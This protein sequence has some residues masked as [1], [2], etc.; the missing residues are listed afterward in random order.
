MGLFAVL[1]E[2][3]LSVQ[4]ILAQLAGLPAYQELWR[5]LKNYQGEQAAY[6]LDGTHKVAL[7]AGLLRDQNTPTIIIVRDEKQATRW[8]DTLQILLPKREIRYFPPVD[9]R[10]R[11]LLLADSHHLTKIRLDSLEILQTEPNGIIVTTIEA[12]LSSLPSPQLLRD[13]T[14]HIKTGQRLDF[15]D[16]RQN[17]LTAGYHRVTQVDGRAQFSIRGD[18]LDIY[19][20]QADPIRIEFFGDEVDSLR[21]FDIG[22]QRT[23][24][25]LDEVTI[26]PASEQCWLPED[27]NSGLRLLNNDI[28]R[29]LK[30]FPQH[31]SAERWAR[32]YESLRQHSGSYGLEQYAIYFQQAASLFDYAEQP[33]VIWD[34]PARLEDLAVRLLDELKN[35][36]DLLP[37][38]QANI[39]TYHH[40]VDQ[41]R[42]QGKLLTMALL[43]RQVSGHQPVAIHSFTARQAPSFFGQLELLEE[44][45]RQ[46]QEQKFRV[47]LSCNTAHQAQELA[48]FLQE[49]F[50]FVYSVD[51]LPL[52]LPSGHVYVIRGDLAQGFEAP[53]IHLI[54]LTA[55]EIFGTQQR[56][57]KRQ[58]QQS[59][60]RKRLT[61]YRELQV[62]D[63]VVH[64][65]HG[66]GVYQG[67][68]TMEYDGVHR[69]Y[70][71][72]RYKGE[73]RLYVPVEQ[74]QLVQKYIG[75]EGKKPRLYALGNNEWQRV[76][77]RVKASV[78]DMAE[79][80]LK[81]Y[82]KR[83]AVV[84]VKYPADD[85]WQDEFEHSFPFE[86]TEDQLKA[87]SDVK[88]DMMNSK[89]MDRL[90]CGDV[91][92]GKTEVALRAIF[93]AAMHGKQVAVLVP[94]TIL[95]HQHFRTFQSR[96]APY[97]LK[98]AMMS[99]FRSHKENQKTIEELAMGTVDIV[100]GTHAILG[101]KVQ[102]H[103]LG[104]LVI[105]EEQRFGVRHKETIKNLKN[106]IDVIT[107]TATPI[108]RTLHMS[109]VGMR[110]L[111]MIAT[112]PANR[113]P[114]QTY[115][116][117]Y[118][119]KMIKECVERELERGGQV[120]Y[121]HNRVRDIEYVA[122]KLRQMMPEARIA[123]AHGRMNE[124]HLEQLM[125]DFY[126]YEYD[127][128]VST[129]IIESG[130]DIPNVN[131][132]IIE[133]ADQFG[134]AQLYQIR[135]RVGR[136]NR[137]AYAYLTYKKHKVLSEVAEKRLNA[138][139]EFTELGAGFKIALRDLQ[140]RG[141]GNVL[142]PEQSG[143]M[144]QVGYDLYVQL[145]DETI[146][147]LKGEVIEVEQEM[148]MDLNI[149]AFIPNRYISD[150]KLKIEMYK[151]IIGCRHVGD[152][153]DVL[154]ELIDRFGEPPMPVRKLL[155]VAEVKA[156][157]QKLQVTALKRRGKSYGLTF[158]AKTVL[159]PEVIQ[160]WWKEFGTQLAWDRHNRST[161]WITTSGEDHEAQLRELSGI[162]HSLLD[163]V[164][165]N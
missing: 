66:I 164:L 114:V 16:L 9:V 104:L 128:L 96:L 7:T 134:L 160:S 85:Q 127:I 41:A 17:L 150:N 56:K 58:P 53:E 63:Y 133:D 110:D 146:R 158:D 3:V 159:N 29:M 27:M 33:L 71:A 122:G 105:D 10:L 47:V 113:Y 30:N 37:H 68:K 109:M 65:S 162:I 55:I 40:L 82:A 21:Y 142:G 36:Q 38:Q 99:R 15:S 161:I 124:R 112:P 74:I 129:T 108:P 60:D 79:E 8:Q 139:R 98:I 24:R 137:L 28:K 86:E 49:R 95:A 156:A 73:D 92:Y 45:L 163:R 152:I 43:T 52:E 83:E 131:T 153:R 140:I 149:D 75:S 93:K 26:R 84:G 31:H 144:M 147:E 6:G 2:E 141:A 32:D 165:D 61:D 67:I 78:Q 132:L 72:I 138:I 126:N 18:I 20:L 151:R 50:S 4:H 107:L 46:W 145:L 59:D 121:L 62:G 116:L 44:Q 91:G 81:L 34:D 94:T 69:D 157:C 117:E 101:S 154:D 120:Y 118:D 5:Q 22:D 125:L 80:L 11:H 143:F 155:L 103:D 88:Q 97:P 87:I 51:E 89:P 115:I 39:F 64:I 25:V 148:E 14:W 76:K 54:V 123:V 70:L 57:V 77:A 130:L 1:N 35:N 23:I 119:L 106:N 111:S 102:F 48:T 13:L 136:T 100:V 90:L 12:I 42:H 19:P 135:G